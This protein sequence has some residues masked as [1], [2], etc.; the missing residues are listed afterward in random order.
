MANSTAPIPIVFDLDGTLID[1]A[2]DIHAAANAVLR[3]HDVPTLTLDRIRSFIGGGVEVLWQKIISDR[4]LDPTTRPQLIAAF[5]T[6]YHEATALTAV[7]PGVMDTLGR[8]S[9]AGHPLGICTNKPLAPTLSVLDHMGLSG[10]FS[11][12]IGGDSLPE[13]KPAPEPLWATLEA[14]GDSRTEPRGIYVGDSEFDAACAAAAGVP[15][16]LFT[17][18]YRLTP[19]ER[20]VH[21]ATFDD[22]AELPALIAEFIK[23]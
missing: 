5:M 21:R 10:L 2:P 6:R 16:L 23:T 12:I 3:Q 1:S 7:Y 19:V 11:Q 8:L 17:R 9:D 4:G 22:Y 15:L 18:G 13:K 20:L 14:L